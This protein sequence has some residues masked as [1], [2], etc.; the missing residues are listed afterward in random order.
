MSDKID[1]EILNDG[2]LKISTDKISMANHAGAEALIREL[3][4]GM[5]GESKRLRKVKGTTQS[6]MHVEGTTHEQ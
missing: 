6:H 1:V 3:V 5:G 4:T 2:S